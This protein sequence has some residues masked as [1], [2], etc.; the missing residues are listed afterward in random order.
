M[1]LDEQCDFPGIP[2]KAP[3]T[4]LVKEALPVSIACFVYASKQVS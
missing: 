1:A 2:R 3:E 4:L